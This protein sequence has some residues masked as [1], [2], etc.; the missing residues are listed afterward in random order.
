MRWHYRDR[1]HVGKCYFAKIAKTMVKRRLFIQRLIYPTLPQR[2]KQLI[3]RVILFCPFLLTVNK[4]S[5]F[6]AA[7]FI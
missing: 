2:V 7:F 6:T 1:A 5:C 4:E 3:H